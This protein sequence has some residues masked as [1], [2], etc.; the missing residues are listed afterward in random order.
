[1]PKQKALGE[2]ISGLISLP[3][4][5]LASSRRWMG[6]RE[7]PHVAIYFKICK[8]LAVL[9]LYNILYQQLYVR[10]IYILF[11]DIQS[12]HLHLCKVHLTNVSATTVWINGRLLSLLYR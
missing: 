10:T 11:D 6:R 1:M 4:M 2:T 9:L 7:R 3:E 5:C 12:P 8:W